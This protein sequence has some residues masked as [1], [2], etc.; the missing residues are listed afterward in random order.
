MF[1]FPEFPA[2]SYTQVLLLYASWL[3]TMRVSPFGHPR[4]NVYLLLP[5][6]YRSLSRPSSAPDAKAFTLCSLSLE[7]L[8]ACSLYLLKLLSFVT[9][10]CYICLFSLLVRL[11]VVLLFYPTF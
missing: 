5:V 10:N 9:V 6:A 1:Q 11:I 4:I 2:Y 3:F 8:L 7:Q